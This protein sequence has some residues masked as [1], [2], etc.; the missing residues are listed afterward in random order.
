MFTPCAGLTKCSFM[1]VS[2]RILTI[3]QCKLYVS[4]ICFSYALIG[5]TEEP[6]IKKRTLRLCDL[7]S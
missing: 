5:K 3:G 7:R 1:L 6:E 4:L 2:D